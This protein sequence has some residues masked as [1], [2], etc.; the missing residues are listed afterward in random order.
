MM[1]SC[2]EYDSRAGYLKEDGITRPET[3]Y[4]AAKLA[5]SLVAEKLAAREGIRFVWARL[6]Y[7][8]GP[9]EDVRRMVPGVIRALLGGHEFQASEGDQVRDY[10]HVDD[11]AS[12]LM[13]LLRA[14]C[15]GVF[16]VCSGEPVTVR[17]VMRM[18]G[19][20]IG[21]PGLIRFGGVPRRHWE[22]PFI[23]GDC[24]KLRQLGWRP[25]YELRDALRL[26]IEYWRSK[27]TSG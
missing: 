14:N 23:C 13:T 22:P 16:N 9:D 6:F 20:E 3:L 4:A 17:Q 10:V 21:Q 1:G 8:F 19:D 26:A 18:I 15:S 2:A 5:T 11:A 12:A 25:K 24:S 7:L 27:V